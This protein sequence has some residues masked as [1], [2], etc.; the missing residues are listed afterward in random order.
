MA[1]NVLA[2]SIPVPAAADVVATPPEDCPPGAYG[3]SEHAGTWCRP[4]TCRTD[5]DC[6]TE[7][8]QRQRIYRADQSPRVCREVDLCV[9]DEE[10][11]L[12]GLRPADAPAT[13]RRQVV[14]AAC[15]DGQC[16]GGTQCLS[17]RRCVTV[18]RAEASETPEDPPPEADEAEADER[19]DPAASGSSSSAP[20]EASGAETDGD[21]EGGGACAVGG[22]GSGRWGLALVGAVGLALLRRRVH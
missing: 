14:R 13:G 19:A 2:L 6:T 5:R 12:G 10:Y 16:N 21:G 1:L 18:A 3:H 7:G 17:E 4:S 11:V 8:L 20:R 9:I 22:A 15:R